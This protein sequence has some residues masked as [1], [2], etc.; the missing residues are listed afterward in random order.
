MQYLHVTF[1]D[2][3]MKVVELERREGDI[4]FV[5]DDQGRSGMIPLSACKEVWSIEE[6]EYKSMVKIQKEE[7]RRAAPSRL[8]APK[9]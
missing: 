7:S 9:V 5:R 3:L 8:I 1:L 6:I 4:L 2:M